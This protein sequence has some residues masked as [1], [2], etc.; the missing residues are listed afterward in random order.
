MLFIMSTRTS[1]LCMSMMS[2]SK[3]ACAIYSIMSTLMHLHMY[4]QIKMLVNVSDL[5]Y[6]VHILYKAYT[7]YTHIHTYSIC[8]HCAYNLFT[9]CTNS[10]C[11]HYAHTLYAYI[12]HI[13]YIF[14]LCTHIIFT[15]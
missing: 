5:A 14:T 7:L 4:V 11:L 10:I 9:F 8:L 1:I 13:Q 15:L 12:M 3:R 6:F 2:M